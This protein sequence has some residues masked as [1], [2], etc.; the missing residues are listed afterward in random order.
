MTATRT[1]PVPKPIQTDA[2]PQ[3]LR[4]LPQWVGWRYKWKDGADD[5]PGEWTKVPIDPHT[6]KGADT[7]DPAT[8][9]TFDDAL[10]AME[11][12]RHDGI[13]FVFI[14]PDPYYFADLDRC[15]DL[16]M[17]AP[18][19]AEIVEALP[20][21]YWERSV[22]GNGLHGIGRGQLPDKHK[23]RKNGGSVEIY[24]TARFATFT[25][26]VYDLHDEIGGDS[27]G[28]I[29][30]VH[31]SVFGPEPARK[32]P[33]ASNDDAGSLLSDDRLIELASGAAN[34]AKFRRLFVDG[35][36]SEHG[37]DASSA[38]IAL[39]NIIAF[40]ARGDSAQIERIFSR[41]ALGR[42]DKW[43]NRQ[44][45]RDRTI[46]EAIDFVTEH[47]TPSASST[48]TI[49]GKQY[50]PGTPP[51]NGTEP[52]DSMPNEP[53]EEDRAIV[54][55]ALEGADYRR[56]DAGNAERLIRD[57]GINLRYGYAQKAWYVYHRGVW[58]EDR[59]A[60]IDKAA[61]KAARR[62]YAE[63]ADISGDE[64]RDKAFKFASSSNRAAGIAGMERLA[65]SFLPAD[66]DEL[67]LDTM[68]LNVRNGTIDL[69]TGE[70]RSHRRRDSITM[71]APVTYDPTATAPRFDAFLRSIFEDDAALLDYAQCLF[72]YAITGETREDV[73]SILAGNG[74]NGKS[75]LL[76]IVSAL[77]GPY[78][79]VSSPELMLAR[80]YGGGDGRDK[81]IAELFG[82]RFV[83]AIETSEGRALNVAI[84]KWLSG[85]DT[86]R[87]RENYK[88]AIVFKPTHT[89]FLATNHVPS[90]PTTDHGTWRRLKLLPFRVKYWRD[91]DPERPPGTPPERMVDPTLKA[92]LHRAMPGILN[93]LVEGCL[94]WQRDGLQTPASVWNATTEYRASQDVVGR[95]ID[96][97]CVAGA[98]FSVA[99]SAL[100]KAYTAWCDQN[101][102][103]KESQ[104]AFGLNLS[105]RG[106]ES[107]KKG[108]YF[109]Y[110]IGLLD[111]NGEEPPHQ[112]TEERMYE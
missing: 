8:W 78:A 94:R 73:V 55:R 28:A 3:E 60:L 25:G 98:K 108:T 57:F 1:R 20:G 59:G 42:R 6:R 85:G 24:T 80:K 100:Y 31:R 82:K 26:D 58:Q 112:T 23:T 16:D 11:W 2:I 14:K 49:G 33:G 43:R 111:A 15:F 87:G 36:L 52:H 44:D 34:G 21:C 106:F 48:P 71:Q 70:L 18:W 39:A 53:D 93:W 103:E 5:K 22:S 90:V 61:R 97:R 54:D 92:T 83:T 7:T 10:T 91:D 88:S 109:R 27:T 9:G 32:A 77:L 99:S 76:E 62:L 89:L 79:W 74:A 75:T 81:E 68:L 105:G 45:Y 66:L 95:F 86:L 69:R 96:E 29:T 41:S 4:D 67:N 13:G 50:E 37:N 12:S 35:D 104:T 19:A 40:Y 17:L 51:P 63:A 102:E 72:G 84:L 110:G 30:T 107:R 38:D 101:G 65:R 56:T 46:Q 47:Y 64:E